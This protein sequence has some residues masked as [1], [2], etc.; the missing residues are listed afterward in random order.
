MSQTMLEKV[1]YDL[2]VDRTARKAFRDD[3]RALLA[4][5]RLTTEEIELICAFDLHALRERGVNPMLLMGYWQL[6]RQDMAS[7]LRRIAGP[8]D[9]EGKA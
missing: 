3:P 6:A 2:S 5:Y 4:T 9:T 8:R 7:Y 1:L